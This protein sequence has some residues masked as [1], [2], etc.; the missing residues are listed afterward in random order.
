MTFRGQLLSGLPRDMLY[1]AAF[2]GIG[3][4]VYEVHQ[5]PPHGCCPHRPAGG[6]ECWCAA[7]SRS[8]WNT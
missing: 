4:Y 6:R 8:S 3:S 2:A 5:K 1:F 7:D